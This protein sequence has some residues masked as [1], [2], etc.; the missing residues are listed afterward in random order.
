[1]VTVRL[2]PDGEEVD[3]DSDEMP[4]VILYGSDVYLRN[5]RREGRYEL[6]SNV[7]VAGKPIKHDVSESK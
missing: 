7:L 6:S 5:A 1:M 2:W 4:D 3:V